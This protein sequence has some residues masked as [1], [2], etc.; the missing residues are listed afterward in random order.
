MSSQTFIRNKVGLLVS[1]RIVNPHRSPL[2]SKESQ[3]KYNAILVWYLLA[4][5]VSDFR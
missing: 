5:L 4:V 1:F 2:R 3:K